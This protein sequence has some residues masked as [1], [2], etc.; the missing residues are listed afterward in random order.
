VTPR[1]AA[2]AYHAFIEWIGD[3]TSLPD[4]IL[5]IHAGMVVLLLARVATGRSLGSLVPLAVVAA[6]EAFNEGMDRLSYGS[7][8]WAD[9]SLDIVN[10]L[11]WPTVICLAIRLRPLAAGRR[12]RRA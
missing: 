12:G 4:T 1:G 5:H 9:T 8:R 7:W 2:H 11:L 10:T 6:A 3:G